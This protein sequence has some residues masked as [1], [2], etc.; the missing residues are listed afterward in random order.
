MQCRLGRTQLAHP[1]MMAHAWCASY[2]LWID[3]RDRSRF[4]L[5][6]PAG[7]VRSSSQR[8]SQPRSKPRLVLVD[9]CSLWG[10]GCRDACLG[11]IRGI[12]RPSVVASGQEP[13]FACHPYRSTCERL[14]PA[15]GRGRDNL[16]PPR[17]RSRDF[18]DQQVKAPV[19]LAI[20]A[21]ARTAA[22]CAQAD[23]SVGQFS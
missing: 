21:K 12:W 10:R 14:A 1:Y 4:G 23:G 22:P 18:R 7:A 6:T 9:A 20:A 5:S 11:S 19:D 2:S 3:L 13:S 17:A 15:A 8:T 16:C